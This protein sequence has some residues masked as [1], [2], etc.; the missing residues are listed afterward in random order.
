[1]TR[2]ANF[3]H[4]ISSSEYLVHII[5]YAYYSVDDYLKRL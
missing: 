3:T 4:Y 5:I 2:T 1:M